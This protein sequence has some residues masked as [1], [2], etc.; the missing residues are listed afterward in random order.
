M[1]DTIVR[2]RPYATYG[3][4]MAPYADQIRE[5]FKRQNQPQQPAPAAAQEPPEEQVFD[6]AKYFSEKW[7]APKWEDSYDYAIRG[8]RPAQRDGAV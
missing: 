2:T 8:D 6:A 7:P 4:Q 1:A 3:Q 5:Y